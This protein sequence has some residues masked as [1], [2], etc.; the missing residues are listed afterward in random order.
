MSTV[1]L[2]FL[3]K[4]GLVGIAGII[5]YLCIRDYFKTKEENRN[6]NVRLQTM[7]KELAAAEKNAE[8]LAVQVQKITDNNLRVTG[9]R[10]RLNEV[11][12]DEEVK[13][14]ARDVLANRNKRVLHIP[15]TQKR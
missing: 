9:L 7:E 4:F 10:T 6:L 13:S 1:L 8:I 14:I 2:G 11:Q 12:N 5:V 15:G 3:W